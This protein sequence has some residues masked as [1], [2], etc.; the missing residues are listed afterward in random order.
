M[1]SA[2]QFTPAVLIERLGMYAGPAVWAYRDSVVAAA[3]D[4]NLEVDH[5]MGL[6]QIGLRLPHRP[7]LLIGWRID[8]GW[9]LVHRPGPGE[10]PAIGPTLY[11]VATDVLDRLLPDPANVVTWLRSIAH[12]G[13]PP[14]TVIPGDPTLDRDHEMA[15]LR[16]LRRHLLL[17]SFASYGADDQ[18]LRRPHSDP[19]PHQGTDR[20][21][22]IL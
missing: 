14:G 11:R 3:C 7:D 22:S 13:C 1:Q 5:T 15:V 4:L 10:P 19:R 17:G 18:P 8:H 12:G 2:T 16:R 9:Y 6:V 21:L 20:P